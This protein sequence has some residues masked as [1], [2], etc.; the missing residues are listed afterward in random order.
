M[1]LSKPTAIAMSMTGRLV[2]LSR[3]MERLMRKRFRYE[4][5]VERKDFLKKR[6][7]CSRLRETDPARASRLKGFW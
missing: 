7:N 4:M 6:Q 1:L 5:G 2:S 3:A